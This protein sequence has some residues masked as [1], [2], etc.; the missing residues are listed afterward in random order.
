MARR[1]PHH[2]MNSQ[3]RELAPARVASE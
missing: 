2:H 3:S 1:R